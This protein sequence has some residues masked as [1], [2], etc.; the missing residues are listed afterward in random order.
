MPNSFSDIVNGSNNFN[1]PNSYDSDGISFVFILA[2]PFNLPCAIWNRIS[3]H[4]SL[5]Y[6]GIV[7]G[8]CVY[9]V[10]VLFTNNN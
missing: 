5:V 1:A 2:R 8:S 10:V 9:L 6:L 7:C 4:H 3:T